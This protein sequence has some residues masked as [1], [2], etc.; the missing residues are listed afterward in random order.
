M[1]QS[2]SEKV[3]LIDAGN[4]RLKWAVSAGG[5]LLENGALGYCWEALPQQLARCWASLAEATNRPQRILLANVAGARLV[6]AVEQWA[7]ALED[8]QACE[9]PVHSVMPEAEAYG[10]RNAY[11]E[12]QRLGV[13]RWLGLL[14]ARHYIHGAACVVDSGTAL[15]VDIL[16][17]AG[18]HLGGIIVPGITLMKT[19]LVDNTQAIQAGQHSVSGYLGRDTQSAIHA[20]ALAAASGAVNQVVAQARAELGEPV[21]AVITGGDAEQLL[22]LLS[23]PF[24]HE[25]HWVLK[26]LA[27]VAGGDA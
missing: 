9:L 6:A 15:T 13:D 7:A 14:A 27:I 18:Q 16:S 1:V 3:L 2:P 11:A 21:N 26:G 8:E 4:S 22:P 20:G 5:E 25:P 19:S 23:D 17:A 10:V 24:R 12:P